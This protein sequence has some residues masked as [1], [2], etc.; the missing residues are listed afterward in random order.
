MCFVLSFLS[1]DILF[2]YNRISYSTTYVHHY[3]KN[4]FAFYLQNILRSYKDLNRL[5]IW[6]F[7]S[8]KPRRNYIYSI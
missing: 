4:T 6:C 1:L 8:D 5:H 3:T 7:S 2:S